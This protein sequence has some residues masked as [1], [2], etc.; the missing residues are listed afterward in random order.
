MLTDERR[1][2]PGAGGASFAPEALTIA[3][4]LPNK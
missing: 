2:I 1:H 4:R 3:R